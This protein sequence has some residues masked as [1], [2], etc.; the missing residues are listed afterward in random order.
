[1]QGIFNF[2]VILF[3]LDI[4]FEINYPSKNIYNR[5]IAEN[6]DLGGEGFD[7]SQGDIGMQCGSF[8]TKNVDNLWITDELSLLTS[9]NSMNFTS[10]PTYYS[11]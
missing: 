11:K 6:R 2:F 5:V 1:M 3:N 10:L 8:P 7:N 9:Q 4:S